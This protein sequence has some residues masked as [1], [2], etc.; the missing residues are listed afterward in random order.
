MPSE[1]SAAAEREQSVKRLTRASRLGD[2]VK[3]CQ[4]NHVKIHIVDQEFIFI[5]C[6]ATPFEVSFIVQRGDTAMTLSRPGK[7]AQSSSSAIALIECSE[8]APASPP[9]VSAVNGSMRCA[10]VAPAGRDSMRAAAL[11]ISQGAYDQVFEEGATSSA[12]RSCKNNRCNW[13]FV[14]VGKLAIET[15]PNIKSGAACQTR[16]PA[17]SDQTTAST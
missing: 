12:S 6:L 5:T 8:A 13:T 16:R 1:P 11:I 3:S 15:A 17:F 10:E 9:R 2:L 14:R 7:P 4:S